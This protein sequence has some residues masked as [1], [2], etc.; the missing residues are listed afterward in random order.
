MLEETPNLPEN[1]KIL[2]KM[3]HYSFISKK[4]KSILEETEKLGNALKKEL[5]KTGIKE[6]DFLALVDK[7]AES[8]N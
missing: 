3:E 1:L 7:H 8:S 4:H 5:T 6:K 2:L